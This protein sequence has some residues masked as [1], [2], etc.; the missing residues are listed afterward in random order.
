MLIMNQGVRIAHDSGK[1]GGKMS[2]ATGAML[3]VDLGDDRPVIFRRTN[4]SA[5]Q[6]VT[7]ALASGKNGTPADAGNTVAVIKGSLADADSP[8]G[9]LEI[10]TNQGKRMQ[11]QWVL[12][13]PAAEVSLT[14][15]QAIPN[16][17]MI[18]LAFAQTRYDTNGIYDDRKEPTR[19]TCHTAGRYAISACVEFSANGAGS[20]QVMVRLNGR[21]QVAAT[22]VAAVEGETTQITFTAPPIELKEGDYVELIV[23]QT[24]GQSLEVPAKGEQSPTFSMTRVG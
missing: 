4:A 9:R 15:G 23:R 19:L 5:T 24:S 6:P 1:T 8:V 16:G 13:V 22:R 21:E 3:E 11:T 17:K 20:R 10:Q 2:A 12:P 18:T 14:Q 7:L